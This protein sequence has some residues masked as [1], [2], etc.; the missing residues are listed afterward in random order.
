MGDSLT[1][2]HLVFPFPRLVPLV[3]IRSM[4]AELQ[5]QNRCPAVAQGQLVGPGPVI[6]RVGVDKT[7]RHHQPLGV[8]GLLP[9]N[10]VLGDDGD[11]AVLDA[12]VGYGVI[13]GFRVHDPA[14][15]DDQI[16]IGS[17]CRHDH[18]QA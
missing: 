10:L 16:V 5:V 2:V 1:V 8:D 18:R 11:P 15:V 14:V 9:F 12:D 3:N 4:G 17:H 7:R 6:V 13:L